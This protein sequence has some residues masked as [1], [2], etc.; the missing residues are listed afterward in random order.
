M[1]SDQPS[2][3]VEVTFSVWDSAYPFVYATETVDCVFELAEMLPRGENQY[4]EFF[5]ITGTDTQQAAALAEGHETVDVSILRE[6]DEGGLFEFLTSGNCP[7]FMLAELGALPQE[8]TCADG[9]GRIVAEVPPQYDSTT[10]IEEFLKEN[11]EAELVSKREKDSFSP[12]F[13][14]SAFQQVLNENLTDRQREVLRVAFESGYYEWPRECTG[15]EVAEELGIS[16]ATFSEHVH[17]A[18]H[19]LMT[20][21]FDGS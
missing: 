20:L 7:A 12:L 13:S 18:E 4:A 17:A 2:P 21:L 1:R 16:S 11:S 3:V 6:H 19:K 5:N 9:E 15:A 10:V 8:V 14:R